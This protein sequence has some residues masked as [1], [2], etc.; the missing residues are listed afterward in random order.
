MAAAAAEEAKQETIANPKEKQTKNDETFPRRRRKQ[1]AAGPLL[2]FRGC[3]HSLRARPGAFTAEV[4]GGRL[5]PYR[6]VCDQYKNK[7]SGGRDMQY[8]SRRWRFRAYRSTSDRPQLWRERRRRGRPRGRG[9]RRFRAVSVVDRARTR[10]RRRRWQKCRCGWVSDR[11]AG[12][13]K[14]GIGG[15]RLPQNF[16]PFGGRPSKKRPRVVGGRGTA[17]IPR[18]HDQ[19]SDRRKKRRNRLRGTAAIPRRLVADLAK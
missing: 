2:L 6:P 3:E 8:T 16:A 10:N 13:P 9:R 15:G 5:T 14:Q 4:D 12:R 1:T 11:P 19:P 7:N 17:A 18:G